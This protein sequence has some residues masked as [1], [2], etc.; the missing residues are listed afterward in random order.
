MKH[1][2]NRWSCCPLDWVLTLCSVLVFGVVFS[3]FVCYVWVAYNWPVGSLVCDIILVFL[4]LP[5]IESCV[6]CWT[7]LFRFLICFLPYFG[8]ISHWF[9]AVICVY[10]SLYKHVL[11]EIL[12]LITLPSKEDSDKI[13]AN[14]TEPS[15]LAYTKYEWICSC[16]VWPAPLLFTY[17]KI[18]FSRGETHL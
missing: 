5:H 14:S 6:R 7:S 10:A 1:Q 12:V 3:F 8:C 2:T 13:C 4:S 18:W 9:Y 16:A 17:N 15:L 11:G